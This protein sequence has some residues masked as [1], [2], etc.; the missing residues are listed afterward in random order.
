VRLRASC[1]HAAATTRLPAHP[2]VSKDRAEPPCPLQPARQSGTGD[3]WT[4][5]ERRQCGVPRRAF[6][7]RFKPSA[8]MPP[9]AKAGRRIDCPLN[10]TTQPQTGP[11][12]LHWNL[13]GFSKYVHAP[14]GGV[15]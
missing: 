7:A 15:V 4:L 10:E 6:G 13:T 11:S 3:R 1:P 5:T 2:E 14:W 9:S 8:R 12:V